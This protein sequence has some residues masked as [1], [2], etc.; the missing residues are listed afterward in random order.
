[1]IDRIDALRVVRGHARDLTIPPTDS[2]EFAYLA[3]RLQLDSP[4]DLHHALT[5]R[6]AY[7]ASLWD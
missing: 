1:M 4:S 2:R 6:M 5:T 3:R 7:A